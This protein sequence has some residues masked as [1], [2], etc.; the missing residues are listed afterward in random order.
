MS[1]TFPLVFQATSWRNGVYWAA[2]MGSE[3][4]AAAV[5]QAAIRRDPF[6]MLPFCG[7]NMG[8]YWNHWLTFED[9]VKQLPGIFRVNW[10]RKDGNGKFVWPGFG[11]NM[12]V[13][14]W[15][16]ERVHG[17]ASEPALSPLGYSPRYQD[18]NWTGL[19]FPQEK[20]NTIM[21]ID[22]KEALNEAQDQVELFDRF[23]QRLPQELEQER[24]ALIKRL[25]AAPA[26]WQIG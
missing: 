11:D 26:V 6:A 4:T 21:N 15:I 24:Q 18:L 22:R 19:D 1:K 9:K 10:F 7:Y 25:E 20:F 13:L 14:Q 23:G 2:T 16:V 3:A 12:R 5:G 17:R 8:D